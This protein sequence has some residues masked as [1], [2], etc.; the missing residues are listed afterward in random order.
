VH[1]ESEGWW[2]AGDGTRIR[3]G[4]AHEPSGVREGPGP[5]VPGENVRGKIKT[6]P[7]WR[8]LTPL[9]ARPEP[10]RPRVT[11]LALP[12]CWRQQVG[13]HV[14]GPEPSVPLLIMLGSF[15]QKRGGMS[16]RNA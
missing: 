13:G 8:G 10:Y 16:M 1:T 14:F 12:P 15:Y 3:N 11:G 4:V 5:V 7:G 2:C 9:V 6:S